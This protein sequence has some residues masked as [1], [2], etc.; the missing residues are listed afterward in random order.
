MPSKTGKK[1]KKKAKL[2]QGNL[3][4]GGKRFAGGDDARAAAEQEEGGRVQNKYD[5]AAGLEYEDEF[6]D[7]FEEEVFINE[8]DEDDDQMDEDTGVAEPTRIFVPGVDQLK[9]G[10]E[11]TFD[12]SAYVLYHAIRPE[13]PSLSFDILRDELGGNR[14]RFPHTL[15]AVTGSQAETPE[16]NKLTVM[17]LT[18][19]HRMPRAGR[20]VDEGD[21]ELAIS[22][23]ADE[24]EDDVDCEDCEPKIDSVSVAHSG[25]AVNRVR[26]CPQQPATVATMGD[27]SVVRVFDLTTH[28]QALNGVGAKPAWGDTG[29]VFAFEG[30]REEGFALDWSPVAVGQLATGDCA[31]RI[32]VWQPGEGG[33]S[34]VV[35]GGRGEHTGSVEDVQWSP[36]EATVFISCSVDRSLKVWDVRE[37]RRAMVTK[38]DAHQSDVNVISWNPSVAYLLA[39]G[40]DDGTF[41]IWDLR[42]F[43]GASAD[44]VAHFRWHRKPVTSLEWHPSD[45]S[46]VA[47]ASEDDS[48][49]VWD[50]SVEED[51]V[52]SSSGGESVE[53]PPQ[54]LF[55]HQGQSSIKEV[56]F[57]PQIPGLLMSTA[58]D[59]YNV[60][61]PNTNI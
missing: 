27:D 19:L 9:E 61:K 47:V 24:D 5:G 21:S 31:G 44:P 54:L 53:L 60:F 58:L 41:K 3:A 59:G 26:S 36:S 16:A 40:A 20:P 28:A 46:V 23:A 56:H 49:T 30:H 29:P 39:S 13:W 22:L 48:I 45:E 37:P 33:A 17:K 2:Q 11:L 52:A 14:S 10:E 4:V 42:S 43:G 32:H 25:A 35:D 1:N 18:D 6:G 57:H 12:P 55:V 15:F 8:G 38:G 7:D 51:A 34:W 50:M